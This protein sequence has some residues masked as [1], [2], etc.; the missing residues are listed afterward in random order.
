MNTQ[1]NQQQEN[2]H[3]LDNIKA[4]PWVES[5]FGWI[6]VGTHNV[7]IL[8]AK[9]TRAILSSKLDDNG[10]FLGFEPKENYPIGFD[11]D[12]LWL[13]LQDS[14][15]R[16][17][18]DRAFTHAWMKPDDPGASRKMRQHNLVVHPY[19]GYTATKEGQGVMEVQMKPVNNQIVYERTNSRSEVCMR[20]LLNRFSAA[21]C[22]D[23]VRNA[24]QLIGQEVQIVVE[25][26]KQRNEVVAV[27]KKDFRPVTNTATVDGE[28]DA[29][30]LADWSPQ[31]S[32]SMF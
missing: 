32:F 1:N 17:L 11:Q 14:E 26:R 4:N 29:T 24:D 9:W 22:T 12:V 23:S 20:Q 19:N 5:R 7:T 13:A 25:R 6:P 2:G 3:F 8:D 30:P 15:G 16:M 10:K 18:I 28:P 31:T 27:F 21:G